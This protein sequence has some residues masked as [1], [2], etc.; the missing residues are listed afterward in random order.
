MNSIRA[1]LT[2][3]LVWVCI[4]MTFTVFDNIPILKG[5][6]NTQATIVAILVILFAAFGASI[7]YKNGIKD[8]G[9]IVGIIMALSAL[10]L[11]ALI[12]VPL[13]EIPNGNTY[14][15][16]FTYPL[17]WLIVVVNI[18]TVYMYWR[19]IVDKRKTI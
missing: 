9:L 1:I 17:L 19:L 18:T 4:F 8:N 15:G 3:A 10:V 12:T 11:D 13:I 2:G 7:Y 14:E 16:F 5:S 6:L